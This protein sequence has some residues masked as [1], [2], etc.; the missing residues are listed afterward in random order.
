[1]NAKLS[2]FASRDEA[3]DESVAAAATAAAADLNETEIRSL[4]S[5]FASAIREG[6]GYGNATAH[7]PDQSRARP[8]HASQESATVY[9]VIVEILQPLI[10]EVFFMGRHLSSSRFVL[11]CSVLR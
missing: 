3:P 10:D 7:G 11:F 8:C 9:A 6:A 1:V 4:A 5:G 2:I